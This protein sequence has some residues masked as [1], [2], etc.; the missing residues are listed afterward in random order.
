M[1]TR[2]N[3]LQMEMVENR[4]AH[5]RFEAIVVQTCEG[6]RIDDFRLDSVTGA[7]LCGNL[8][9]FWQDIGGRQHDSGGDQPLAQRTC[10]A[11]N[12]KDPHAGLELAILDDHVG[13]ALQANSAR[14]P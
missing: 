3:I 7:F 10:A 5:D 11:T 9:E 6:F 14:T 12:L 2:Q 4:K 13:S 1:N 8:Q